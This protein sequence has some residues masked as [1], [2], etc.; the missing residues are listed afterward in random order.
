M[1]D[2]ERIAEAA[3]IAHRYGMIDGEHHKQWVIDQMLRAMLAD[4]Y[5]N[6]VAEMN[7]EEFDPWD[8]GIAP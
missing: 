2:A 7:S 1:T 3:R 8:E 4:G 5:A 6:W